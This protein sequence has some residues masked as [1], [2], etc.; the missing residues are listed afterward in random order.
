MPNPMQKRELQNYV[1]ASSSPFLVVD[2]P[3]TDTNEQQQQ[4]R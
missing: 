3:T 4:Q 2:I 1:R